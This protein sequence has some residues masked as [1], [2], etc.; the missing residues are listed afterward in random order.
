MSARCIPK[1]IR[2]EVVTKA[3][4]GEKVSDLAER[5]GISTKTIYGWLTN[6]SGEDTISVLKYNKL[7][8]EN[9]EL[10]RIIGKLT[11]D[12]SWEKKGKT[13]A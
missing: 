1:E 13:G 6:D 11:L 3:K 8:R 7:K 12:M 2:D 10:K 9:E 4:T 5:Y